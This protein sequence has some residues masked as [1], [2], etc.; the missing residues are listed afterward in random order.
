[1]TIG[2]PQTQAIMVIMASLLV[3]GG[4]WYF[5]SLLEH[6]LAGRPPHGGNPFISE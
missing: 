1:M 5:A 4:C 6:P 2:S 3:A